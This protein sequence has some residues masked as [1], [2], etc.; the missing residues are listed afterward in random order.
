MARGAGLNGLSGIKPKNGRILRPLIYLSKDEIFSLCKENN[1]E[2]VTDST[3]TDTDYT[4]NYI[5]SQ[6][7]PSVRRLNPDIYGSIGRMTDTLR[8][9]EDFILSSAVSFV[10]K[11][12]CGA[13][14]TKQLGELHPAVRARVFKLSAGC[15]LDY[16]S[17]RL[18]EDLVFN[19]KCGSYIDLSGGIVLKKER[20]FV[21][22]LK[23]EKMDSLEYCYEL[24]DGVRIEEIG[25][26]VF[27]NSMTEYGCPEFS[28]SINKSSLSGKLYIRSRRDGD[29]IFQG[30]MSK[31]IKTILCDKHIPSHLRDRIP[32]I[33]DDNGIVAIGNLCM[34]DGCKYRGN[35]EKTEI[36]FYQIVNI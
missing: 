2:Y 12:P 7:V 13:L 9:D 27:L 35:G 15:N 30:G 32:I 19:S 16:K 5:R 6:I 36:I 3:N 23:K 24:Y 21:H 20:D 10:A 8:Q 18:C 4:R 26:A 1:I 22:F 25:K 14:D 33:C 17:I 34:R 29:R 11:S 31:K 28:L